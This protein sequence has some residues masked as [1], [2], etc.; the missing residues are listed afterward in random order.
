MNYT[1][2]EVVTLTFLLTKTNDAAHEKVS[3]IIRSFIRGKTTS[4]RCEVHLLCS[5]LGTQMLRV[6]LDS[7]DLFIHSFSFS[8]P[9]F[10][11]VSVPVSSVSLCP[12]LSPLLISDILPLI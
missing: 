7:A 9:A 1:C 4:Q 11:L 3:V 12:F 8:S 10:L 6:Q 5:Y 2:F